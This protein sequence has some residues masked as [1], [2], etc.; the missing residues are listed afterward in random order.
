MTPEDKA[1]IDKLEKLAGKATQGEWENS[2]GFVRTKAG[3]GGGNSYQGNG[4]TIQ[5]SCSWVADCRN[6]EAF[7]NPGG[8][9][10]YIAACYPDAILRLI[11][12]VRNNEH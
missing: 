8:N 2:C 12:L 1:F 7:Y 10:N 3:T 11:A 6:G 4:F 5:T 9:A